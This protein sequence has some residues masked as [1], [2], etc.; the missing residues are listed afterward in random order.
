MAAYDV[1]IVGMG[2]AGTVMANLLGQQGIKTCIL[3][4]FPNPYPL[5]RAV[6][7]DGETMRTLQAIGVA[8]AM[9][10]VFVVNKGMQFVNSDNKLLL[11]WPR[12]QEIGSDGWYPS[13]RLHQPDL[14]VEM[15]KSV[16]KFDC[17]DQIF[18]VEVYKITQNKDSAQLYYKDN[19]GI[20]HIIDAKYIVG[21]DGARSLVRNTINPELH[22]M[23]SDEK[24]LVVDFLTKRPTP[25]L[26]DWTI[27][28][29]DPK[30]PTTVARAPANRRRW[31][32]ML[33]DGDVEEDMTNEDKLWEL[34]AP[35]ISKED[36]DLE[37]A[38]VYQFHAYVFQSWREGRFILVGDACH[39]TPPFM[40]QG[41]CAG[42]RDAI[43][44][45]WKL[46]LVIKGKAKDELL[47]TYASE[48]IPPA[49]F[50]ITEATRLGHL[51]QADEASAKARDE[52]LS[53]N[54]EFLVVKMPPL[55]PGLSQNNDDA[56]GYMYY[57]G[58]T[59]TGI[60]MDDYF[61]YHFG[62]IASNEVLKNAKA[63]L[64]QLESKGLT[65]KTLA[66]EDIDESYLQHY[67]QH[68][69][70]IRPDRFVLATPKDDKEIITSL[71]KLG[72]ILI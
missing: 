53:T 46:G 11:N 59:K 24:W 26:S 17:V 22:D 27:Q 30:R 68:A 50:L 38:A 28:V 10:E 20:G 14:E 69:L 5:P 15:R 29:C 18:E 63:A 40:G 49:T 3:D 23:K 37:R 62:I 2:P 7:L 8:D 70:L 52:Q 12:P 65:I 13:Y 67:P 19:R 36:A 66:K 32:F 31:E 45:G 21:C 1:A 56:V 39:F 33:V 43:N 60:K 4:R 61:G 48:R 64:K 72:E 16:N 35:W 42:F 6:H 47:D 58:K 71:E 54:P 9:S 57:Q 25:Q 44:L 41:L 34:V 51:L 55:G